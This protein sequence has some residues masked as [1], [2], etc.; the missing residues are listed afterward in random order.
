MCKPSKYII[1]EV[2]EKLQNVIVI[3]DSDFFRQIDRDYLLS[4]GYDVE[5]VRKQKDI[6]AEMLKKGNQ[7]VVKVQVEE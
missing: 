6:T 1:S 4:I 2:A 5:I 7:M 3:D